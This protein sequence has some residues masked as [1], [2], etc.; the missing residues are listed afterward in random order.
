MTNLENEVDLRILIK[1]IREGRCLPIINYH[2]SSRLLVDHQTVIEKWAK[3]EVKYPYPLTD[4]HNLLTR[5]AQYV[6]VDQ[7]YDEAPQ[8][9]YLDF[10]KQELLHREEQSLQSYPNLKTL[11]DDPDLTFSKVAA[12]LNYP[13]CQDMV[14]DPLCILARLPVAIYLTT[15]YSELMEIALRAAG[16]EPQSEICYWREGLDRV[17]SIF[18]KD[19]SYE[20]SK[21]RPLV[22]H[23][24]GLD[25]YPE[26]VVLTEDDYLDFLIKIS[27][28]PKLVPELIS[29]ALVQCSLLLLGYRLHG[30][31]FRTVFKGLIA[32]KPNGLRKFSL[33]IQLRPEEEGID[34]AKAR[35]YLERYFDHQKF[36]IYWGDAQKFTQELWAQWE[37]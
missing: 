22:Y 3:D 9:S 23:L 12:L 21:D 31:D 13:N 35:T 5:I 8:E 6:K 16:K 29:K 20:P 4:Q 32:P 30:W 37:G 25:A 2:A 36:K 19:P 10:L 17:P 1:R 15:S 24:H 11:K 18:K 27:E 26:S 34:I 7:G 33:S 28:D 14:T